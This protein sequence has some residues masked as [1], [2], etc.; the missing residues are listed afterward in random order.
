MA[1]WYTDRSRYETG[2]GECPE[3]RYLTYHAGPSGYGFVRKAESLPLATGTGVHHGTQLLGQFCLDNPEAREIPLSTIRAAASAACTAYETEV[4]SRGIAQW[5]DQTSL[6]FLIAEQSALI[7][8]LVW[9]AGLEFFPWLLDTHEVLCVER[10]FTHVLACTCGLGDGVG[11]AADHEA[12]DCNGICLQ[13]R[14]DLITRHRLNP[15]L[16][17][18]WEYKTTSRITKA[19]QDAWETKIQF[20]ASILPV[21]AELGIRV[22]ETYVVGLWKG[23]R[24]EGSDKVKRQNSVLCYGY[25]KPGQ[26]PLTDDDW[27]AEWE[28]VNADG[29][30]SRLGKGYQKTPVW[31]AT[32]GP[33]T[34]PPLADNMD[35]PVDTEEDPREFW[36]RWLTPQQRQQQLAILGPF[37]RQDTLMRK[38]QLDL[39]GEEKHWQRALW[40]IYEAGQ[41]GEDV[42]A[43]RTEYVR[44]SWNCKKYGGEHA[45]PYEPICFD[46]EGGQDPLG[47]GLFILRR[48]HHAPELEQAVARG[49]L[50]EQAEEVSED[51]E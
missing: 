26:P 21:E 39:V 35:V 17:A 46:K 16:H 7:H 1:L 18:Y 33:S 4:R 23:D 38:F 28:T 25:L 47:S 27:R 41:A 43:A 40:A 31:N 3:R 9:C 8:G 13:T 11:S 5:A 10:E 45:C 37:N 42:E 6:E 34:T 19:W 36:V 20:H 14:P 30:K 15:T 12:R 2:T 32:F 29:S 44:R 51:S 22:S 24:R 48:P 49:L 50:P